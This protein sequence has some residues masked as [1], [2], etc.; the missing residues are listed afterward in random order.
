MAENTDETRDCIRCGEVLFTCE[1]YCMFCGMQNPY[2]DEKEFENQTGRTL[3]EESADCR[4][5][6]HSWVL[7]I[8]EDDPEFINE[9]HFC[10]VCGVQVT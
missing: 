5:G 10:S 1:L 9:K 7:E 8:L 2:F 6:D 3:G 4:K